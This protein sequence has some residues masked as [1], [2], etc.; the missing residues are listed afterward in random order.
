MSSTTRSQKPWVVVVVGVLGALGGSLT[1]WRPAAAC[2][3]VSDSWGVSLLAVE[4]DTSDAS[5]AAY[6]PSTGTLQS[7]E[8]H[9]SI[10]ASAWEPGYV[11]YARAGKL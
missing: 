2:S 5:H 1:A 11:H 3:C 4:S 6:W 9:A 7:Y 10:W 8:G